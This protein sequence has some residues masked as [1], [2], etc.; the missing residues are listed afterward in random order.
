MKRF[1]HPLFKAFLAAVMLLGFVL[2]GSS[3]KA[4]TTLSAGGII[5]TAFSSNAGATIGDTVSFVLL[6]PISSNTQISFTDRG[7]TGSGWVAAGTSEG[8]L[9]WTS[10][11]AL[12]VGTEV[13]IGGGGTSATAFTINPSTGVKTVNGT[14][15]RTDGT[16][17]S[18]GFNLSNVGDQIIAFQGGSGVVSNSGVTLIAGIHYFYCTNAGNNTTIAGWDGSACASSVNGSA[19]P[20]GLTGGTNAFWTGNPGAGIYLSGRFNCSNGA[21]FAN[22][23]A[24]RTAV[25]D[26]SKWTMSTSSSAFLGAPSGCTY[27]STCTTPVFSA[28]PSS[29]TICAGANTS[30]TA[31]ASPVTS[32]KWQVN[33][34]SGFTD[35]TDDA[36]YSGSATNTLS[37]TGA[38]AGMSG[39]QYKVIAYNNGTSC[40]TSSNTA[41]L[42][43]TSITSSV[44]SQTNVSC[45]GGTNGAATISASGGTGTLTYNWTPGNPTGDGT[46]SVSGLTSQ[47]WTCTITDANSCT[48]LQTVNI[49]QPTAITSSVTSQ[50]NVSCNGGTNGSAT[51]TASGGT[52]TLTYSWAPSGGTAA[53]A[54]GLSAQV[55]TVT[56]TDANSCTKLQTVNISQPTAITSS[57]TSQTNV[58]CNGGTNGSATVT[59]SGGTGTLTYSWAPSGGTA[60]AATGLSAQVYTVTITDANSCT[61]LQTVN[62]SQPTAITS[63]VTSQTNVSCNGGTNGSATVTASGGTGTLTYSWAPSGGTAAAA[64][65]LSAQVYTV[66]ITDANSCTK[67]QTVNISQPTAITSSVTSQTNVSCNGGTNGSAT[68][69]ASGGTGTLTYSWAPSGGTAASATG[70]SAQVYTVTIT[71]ANSCAKLQTVNISQPTAITS[72]VTSQTN[73]SCNGGTNGSATVTASGGTGTLTYSWAPSG[74]TAASATGLS[75]QVYTV[76]ITDA[77]SCTKLQTV[78]ISQPTAIT[79]SVTSQTNVSCNGGTN[80]AATISASGG[81]GTLTYNWT[82]GNPTGDGTVSVSGLSAQV[83]TC[84]ITDANSCTKLQTVNISQ[85]TAI[86]SSVTSQTNISCNGG[87]NGAATISASGGTGALT[88]NWTPGNPAGD[89]TVSVTGLSVGVWTCTITDANSCTKLQTVNITQPTVLNLTVSADTNICVPS[90]ISI[91]ATA[92]GGSGGYTYNWTPGNLSGGTQ[93]VSPT[94]TTNYIVTA[95][96]VNSCTKKDTVTVSVGGVLAQSNQTN[97]VSVDGADTSST[98]VVIGGLTYMYNDE[99]KTLASVKQNAS[100]GALLGY[101]TVVDSVPV[102]QGRPFVSRWYQI[103][104]QNNGAGSVNLYFTQQDFDDYNVY[105]TAHSFPKLPQNPTDQVGIDSLVVTKV[106]GGDLVAGTG[107]RTLIHPDSVKWNPSLHFWTVS[108]TIPSFSQFYVHTNNT[109]GTPL[110]VNIGS[111]NVRKEN[112]VAGLYWTT[113]SEMENVGF[114]IQRSMDGKT[115]QT[116]G[117]IASKAVNGNSQ[118]VLS[119]NYYDKVPFNGMNFYRLAEKDKKGNIVYSDIRTLN[120]DGKSDFNCYPNPVKSQLTVEYNSAKDEVMNIRVTDVMGKVVLTQEM[121]LQKGFNKTVMDMSG[122]GQGIYNMTIISNSG[123]VYTSKVIRN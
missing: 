44:T 61:K 38:T 90:T 36:T 91:N 78:N 47:V 101:V 5:F 93:S 4:Q 50:T 39:Y 16:M 54:T 88:Y 48:K 7:Y 30:F 11:S 53:A 109:L 9:T 95:T 63:S 18:N 49:S 27:I 107:T 80:G 67:L 31:T 57:V 2:N 118:S 32:Y 24:L 60:A 75:A 76:T 14:V 42:T 28:Q 1:L 119:Y 29:G 51:V 3:A 59:A 89:G 82:P 105:A 83:W 116:I 35:I 33:T 106:S 92:T 102:Y 21:P 26:A 97:T 81:T 74:G 71:D 23:A 111:F 13:T 77:N 45:N 110:Y 40:N 123:M 41:T 62:I 99:C 43:V 120:F 25:M 34:G 103:T 52:G 121:N 20:P 72:S 19:M 84:T 96:D 22:V 65:G 10:G 37:I 122:L 104:P 15:A 86:T 113:Q 87:S 55:Y 94:V 69:T 108:L 112:G 100:L 46:V 114:D 70:L 117:S 12:P 68:V 98:N 66:T 64:T 56:I 73:V 79:S 8:A 17:A 115:Y 58:S 85:P 6:V